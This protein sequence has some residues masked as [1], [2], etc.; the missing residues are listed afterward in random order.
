MLDNINTPEAYSEP[1]QTA[2]M[3]LLAN[4]I[5]GLELSLTVFVKSSILDLLV[6]PECASVRLKEYF[7]IKIYPHRYRVTVRN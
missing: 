1:S 6:G 3:E 7:Q 4:T 2:K 5:Y